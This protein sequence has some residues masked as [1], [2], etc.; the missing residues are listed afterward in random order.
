MK[1]NPAGQ[2]SI[3]S[4]LA[5]KPE[6]QIKNR[7]ESRSAAGRLKRSETNGSK[8]RLAAFQKEGLIRKK[9]SFCLMESGNS[10]GIGARQKENE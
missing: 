10:K 7:E 5:G 1:K 9:R 4:G 2:K 6:N 3:K 8:N